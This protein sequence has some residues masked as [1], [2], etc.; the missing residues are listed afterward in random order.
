MPER[1]GPLIEAY[2]LD[3][4]RKAVVSDL[5]MLE[6]QNTLAKLVRNA[7]PG[8]SGF[9]LEWLQA[10]TTDVMDR[11]ANDE[12]EVVVTPA[13]SYERAGALVTLA[14]R[15]HGRAFGSW[16]TIHIL[17]AAEIGF[18]RKTVVDLVT[19]DQGLAGFVDLYPQFGKYVN[20]IQVDDPGV[21]SEIT[22]NVA[23]GA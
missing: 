3:T 22:T 10:A 2:L 18:E 5:G 15:E 4:S 14:T 9:D 23:A 16:D 13:K 17:T 20:V 8:H 12:V 1:V 21:A 11:I 19:S 6:F 7:D